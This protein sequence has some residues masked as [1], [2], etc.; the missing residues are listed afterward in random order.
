MRNY[1][2]RRQNCDHRFF[3][4]AEIYVPPVGIAGVDWAG[5]STK[6][7]HTYAAVTRSN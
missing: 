7:K 1:F 2:S 6:R 5:I 3:L 4:L